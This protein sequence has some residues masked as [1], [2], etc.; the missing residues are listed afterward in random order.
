MNKI[1]TPIIITIFLIA[2]SHCQ[3]SFKNNSSKRDSVDFQVIQQHIQKVLERCPI[4]ETNKELISQKQH[5]IDKS[6]QEN[7]NWDK[8]YFEIISTYQDVKEKKQRFNFLSTRK[9]Y[10]EE[11]IRQ[12]D[13]NLLNLKKIYENR[14]KSIPTAYLVFTQ[15]NAPKNPIDTVPRKNIDMELDKYSKSF[16]KKYVPTLITSNTQIKNLTIVQDIV[17]AIQCGRIES[18]ETDP[19][20][21]MSKDKHYFLLQKYRIYIDFSDYK[22]WNPTIQNNYNIVSDDSNAFYSFIVKDYSS[23]SEKIPKTFFVSNNSERIFRMMDEVSA[24]NS[25]QEQKLKEIDHNYSETNNRILTKKKGAQ[26]EIDQIISTISSLYSTPQQLDKDILL[27]EQE[28][29]NHVKE[30]KMILVTTQTERTQRGESILD[31]YTKMIKTAYS[32][33]LERAE[34]LK[35]YSFSVVENNKLIQYNGMNYY[36]DPIP[37]RWEVPLIRKTYIKE[38]G[39]VHKCSVLFVLYV[40]FVKQ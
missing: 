19:I 38:D 10:L 18:F 1:I 21:Q 11:L 39:G 6:E 13:T 37:V 32:D 17:M 20:R 28:L 27:A 35:S 12:Y 26:K 14:L 40:K 30:R 15:K 33:L 7:A 24:F 29:S 25:V 3:A 31:L 36:S 34:Y 5:F 23:V 9:K 22:T 8:K 16:L 2:T 4:T